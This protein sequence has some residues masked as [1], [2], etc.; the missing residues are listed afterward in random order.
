MNSWETRQLTMSHDDCF[1]FEEVNL[2]TENQD[3]WQGKGKTGPLHP[4]NTHTQNHPVDL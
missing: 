4:Y 1:D 3:S 2:D